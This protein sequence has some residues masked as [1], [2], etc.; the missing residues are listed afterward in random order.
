MSNLFECLNCCRSFN[1]ANTLAY[2]PDCGEMCEYESEPGK[3]DFCLEDDDEGDEPPPYNGAGEPIKVPNV[4]APRITNGLLPPVIPS[5]SSLKG[6]AP[7][8]IVRTPP[9]PIPSI[10]VRGAS[11]L[12]QEPIKRKKPDD[13]DEDV[14]SPSPLAPLHINPPPESVM[15]PPHDIFESSLPR[16]DLRRGLITRTGT[17]SA[18]RKSCNSI[19][20]TMT[21]ST[22]VLLIGEGNFS[23]ALAVAKRVGTA[24]NMIATD[25]EMHH[26]LTAPSGCDMHVM[27]FINLGGTINCSTDVTKLS[28]TSPWASK[29]G[30]LD[31]MSWAFPHTKTPNKDKR[32]IPE[33]RS[34]L[35]A[36]IDEAAI[37][38]RMGGV[39]LITVKEGYPYNE[40]EV[41][42]L[43]TD[44]VQHTDFEPFFPKDFPEYR[45]VT[46]VG[47]PIMQITPASTHIFRKMA[48]PS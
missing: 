18:V 37:M 21:P 39:A 4:I 13:E 29:V 11:V 5:M 7:P 1:D 30:K 34:L 46:T 2:C 41:S 20:A 25:V 36:F 40:W 23:F 43:G 9:N 16:L 35:K 10:K 48:E 26:E 31:V 8:P 6:M 42:E 32:C 38:L 45:H 24:A 33:H 27:P 47:A 44:L 19:W 12:P 14:Y 28:T 17:S 3:H 15:L 22:S